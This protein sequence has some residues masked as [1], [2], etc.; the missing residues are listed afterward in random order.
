MKTDSSSLRFRACLAALSLI[1]LTLSSALAENPP[2]ARN[3]PNLMPAPEFVLQHESELGLSAEQHAKLAGTVSELESAAQNAAAQVRRESDALAQLL[4]GAQPDGAVVAAQFEKVLAA[5]NEVKRV[6]LKMSLSARAVI[7]AE[8]RRKLES[9]QNRS[10]PRRTSSP[11][12]QELAVK[13]AAVRDLIERAKTEGSDLGNVREM[14]KRV[15][16]ATQEGKT[17]EAA[18]ILDETAASLS[19]ALASPLKR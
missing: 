10:T 16:E 5:E 13:M 17:G 2:T 4:A 8:Q 12:L 11:E 18:R 7:T 14:W 6:R 1:V 19:A 15:N 3:L 9:L